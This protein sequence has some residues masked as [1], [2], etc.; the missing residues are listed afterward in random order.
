MA[1]TTTVIRSRTRGNI[2]CEQTI[3]ADTVLRRA[4]GL[5]GR[6]SLATDE[7]MLITPSPSIHSAFMRF[8]FDAVFLDADMRVVRVADNIPKWR[9]RGARHARSVLELAAGE[10]ERRGVQ[11]GDH[12]FLESGTSDDL[13]AMATA[14]NSAG[15][16]HGS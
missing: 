7:G 14:D 5:L 6:D 9:A 15:A 13:T 8:A 1:P 4:R 2:V 16:A 12:L 11:V 10:A 3:V